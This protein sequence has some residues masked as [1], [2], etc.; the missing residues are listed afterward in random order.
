MVPEQ[1]LSGD[2]HFAVIPWTRVAAAEK[3]EAPLKLLCGSGVE[4]AALVVRKGLDPAD[5]RSVAIPREGGMKDLTAMG[6]ID[7]MGWSEARQMRFPSG[8]GAIIAFFGQGADAASMVEPY[9]TMMEQLGVGTVVRRTGDIWP[10]AP[11]C[12][13]AASAAFIARE[14]DLIQRVVN[15]FVRGAREVLDNPHGAA[16]AAAPY[17]GV[18][19]AF[20]AEALRYNRPDIDAIRNTDS[21]QTILRFMQSLGY[22]DRI[23]SEFADLSFLDRAAAVEPV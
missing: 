8:D 21:M 13:L 9:A 14:P 3:N 2:C 5:V 20:I 15:A 17:I 7:S 1:L 16:D 6:L 4:E 23:P 10:G 12:S 19:P 22:I 11:G 18:A